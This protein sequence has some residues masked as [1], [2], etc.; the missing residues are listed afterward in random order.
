M[1]AQAKKRCVLVISD[2]VPLIHLQKMGALHL[3]LEL[4]AHISVVDA[5]Y[6]N[7]VIEQSNYDS[8]QEII[9]FLR[10]NA[11][12][13]LT[14]LGNLMLE[15]WFAGKNH[16]NARPSPQCFGDGAVLE[17]MKDHLDKIAAKNPVLLL[18]VDYDMET[19]PNV[20][21]PNVHFLSTVA[22]VRGLEIWRS[23]KS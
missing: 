1:D 17:F 9:T 6:Y 21:P 8:D 22:F 23:K 13:F 2:T 7:L 5:V 4:K 20:F 3:L 15:K 18:C 10:D 19:P 14:Y 11:T 12:I 16:P